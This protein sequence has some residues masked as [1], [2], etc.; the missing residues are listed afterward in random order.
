MVLF[1]LNFSTEKPTE[2]IQII[3]PS[4]ITLKTLVSLVFVPITLWLPICTSLLSILVN[5]GCPFLITVPLAI[6]FA[7][8]TFPLTSTK[9][10]VCLSFPLSFPYLF[11]YPSPFLSFPL[12][13]LYLLSYPS[14]F[15]S[16]PLSFPYLLSFPLS[17]FIPSHPPSS[18]FLS[19][20]PISSPIL[21]PFSLYPFPI[22]SLLSFP[23]SLFPSLSFPSTSFPV[24]Y[25]LTM[26]SGSFNH[27][28]EDF[29]SS[30]LSFTQFFLKE[31][32]K[33]LKTYFLL[34]N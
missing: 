19:L 26:T 20:F 29:P 34:L 5:F 24:C 7:E 13:F 31:L 32:P 3:L 18:P 28:E 17:L 23:L 30:S 2:L 33:Y 22:L 9:F 16:F 25:L 27:Q 14:P 6:P 1:K 21:S 11:F 8:T 4:L 12:S 10:L 15:L